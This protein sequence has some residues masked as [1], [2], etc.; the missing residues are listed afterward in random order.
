MVVK[1]AG[2]KSVKL[3]FAGVSEII[4]APGVIVAKEQ[5]TNR[6]VRFEDPDRDRYYTINML[7][8]IL[9]QYW[10]RPCDV[11]IRQV[12][13]GVELLAG[14]LT[15]KLNSFVNYINRQ[16]GSLELVYEDFSTISSASRKR[17]WIIGDCFKETKWFEKYPFG[18]G[19]KK[20][21]EIACKDKICLIFSYSYYYKENVPRDTREERV[22]LTV[23]ER[24][25]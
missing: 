21:I 16:V 6:E 5:L 10:T 7:M 8:P 18:N 24:P 3:D 25:W 9:Q 23:L 17:H 13:N 11:E 14:P 1:G 2:V 4:V 15:I 22:E 20:V 12:D 19:E